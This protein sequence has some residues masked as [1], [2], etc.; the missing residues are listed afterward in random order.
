MK[1]CRT[2]P[3]KIIVKHTLSS[4]SKLGILEPK[5]RKITYGTIFK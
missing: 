3:E 5:V 4:M 1:C 2:Y